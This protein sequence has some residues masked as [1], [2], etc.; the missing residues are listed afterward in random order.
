MDEKFKT[1]IT[2]IK[3]MKP[4]SVRIHGTVATI[5]WIM[6]KYD[7]SEYE[8]IGYLFELMQDECNEMDSK[9][10]NFEIRQ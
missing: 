4:S 1:H 6:E 10:G 5:R 2:D 9:V 7:F 3:P 8:T